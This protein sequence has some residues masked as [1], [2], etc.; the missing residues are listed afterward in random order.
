MLLTS[1]NVLVT[2]ASSGIGLALS[3]Q[4]AANGATVYPTGRRRF[5]DVPGYLPAD[6]SLQEGRQHLLGHLERETDQIDVAI[7]NAGVL[8]SPNVALRDYEESTWRSVLELNVTAVHL[9]HQLIEPLLTASTV[10]TVIVTSSS[11]GRLGRAG[12]GAYSVAKHAIEGWVT[13]LAAEWGEVG[14]AYSV[15]PGGTATPMRAAAFPDEDPD[16]LPTAED[17]VPV[18]LY[19]AGADCPEPTGARLNAR[20]WIGLDPR[21]GRR[22]AQSDG[23]VTPSK[24]GEIP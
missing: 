6:L 15:N 19:L 18:F 20:D 3:R 5:A 13:V 24:H 4:L 7:Y 14:R 11:V 10:P 8:G 22:I 17:I 23:M 21:N 9:L 16:S 12:W 2:G 1:R